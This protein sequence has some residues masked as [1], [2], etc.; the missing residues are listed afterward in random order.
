MVEMKQS[1]KSVTKSNPKSKMENNPLQNTSPNSVVQAGHNQTTTSN[2]HNISNN[3]NRKP[4][5]GHEIQAEPNQQCWDDF[6]HT[7]YI[8]Y[9]LKPGVSNRDNPYGFTSARSSRDVSPDPSPGNDSGGGDV[10]T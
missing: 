8:N 7:M 1:T 4:E 6:K 5:S 10:V 2:L 3:H 9:W